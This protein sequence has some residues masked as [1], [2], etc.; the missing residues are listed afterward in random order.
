MTSATGRSGQ[1]TQVLWEAGNG[2]AHKLA[3]SL[4]PG[5]KKLGIQG[6]LALTISLSLIYAP[7]LF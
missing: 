2:W 5:Y 4:W 6:A 7:D 1:T 3:Q